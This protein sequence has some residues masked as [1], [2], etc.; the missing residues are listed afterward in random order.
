MSPAHELNRTIMIRIHTY[1]NKAFP[2]HDYPSVGL[3][4]YVCLRA[5]GG[6]RRRGVIN[7]TRSRLNTRVRS[8]I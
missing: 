3:R 1:T 5:R 8:N 2:E 4:V 7:E 6:R